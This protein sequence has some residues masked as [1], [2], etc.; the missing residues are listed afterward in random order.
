[1][2]EHLFTPFFLIKEDGQGIGL[3]VAREVLTR[4]GFDFGLENGPEGAVFWVTL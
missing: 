4:H 1:M 3:M 2:R